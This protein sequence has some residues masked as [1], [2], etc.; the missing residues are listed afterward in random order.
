[1]KNHLG[2]SHLSYEPVRQALFRT[3]RSDLEGSR[4]SNTMSLEELAIRS[5]AGELLEHQSSDYMNMDSNYSIT[6][7]LKTYR[8]KYGKNRIGRFDDND[9]VVDN[10]MISRRHCC[11]V[12]HADERM[13][14]FD[15]ASKNGT[16]VNGQKIQ[17]Y[18][19]K[20]GD[21]INLAR[22]YDLS[23]SF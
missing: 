19:L 5:Y 7:E 16:T 12:V 11:I 3:V 1:M 18:W 9:I 10:I 17:R 20:I 13:E 22:V 4:G 15:T 14:V 6:I 23:I 2:S 8:L 21:K